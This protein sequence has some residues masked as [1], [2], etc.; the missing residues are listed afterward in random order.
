MGVRMN[1]S[2]KAIEFVNNITRVSGESGSEVG[3][4]RI[5]DKDN[6]K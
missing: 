2:A 5:I 3:H 4:E 1:E 6:R